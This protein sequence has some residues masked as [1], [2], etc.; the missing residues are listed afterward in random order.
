MDIHF[1]DQTT[2]PVVLENNSLSTYYKHAYKHLQHVQI[3]FT[4]LDNRYSTVRTEL[5][6]ALIEIVAAGKRVNVEVDQTQCLEQPYLN[7]LHE[8]Y[9]K[10]YVPGIGWLYFHELIHQIEKFI[11]NRNNQCP[12]LTIDYRES[13]GPITAK[14]RPEWKEKFTTKLTQGDVFVSW[15]ELSKPPYSYWEDNEPDN[16]DRL[17]ELA[18]PWLN[19]KPR[20]SIAFEDC[21]LLK[22]KNVEMFNQWWL[23]KKEKWC[24]HWNIDD[25]TI[26][27]MFSCMVFGKISEFHVSQLKEKLQSNI[28]PVKVTP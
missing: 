6:D 8:T 7:F 15:A 22:Y 21:D 10:N 9:E 14:F 4:Q 24:K 16:H 28:I 25:W 5:K 23:P 26:E 12:H 18:K 17:C 1:S 13:S 11:R 27:D 20:I 19:L 2:I 3:P